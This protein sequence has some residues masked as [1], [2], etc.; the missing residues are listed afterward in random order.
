MQQRKK[1]TSIELQLTISRRSLTKL[2]R[3]QPDLEPPTMNNILKVAQASKHV[4]VPRKVRVD[5]VARQ[6]TSRTYRCL[7]SRSKMVRVVTMAGSHQHTTTRRCSTRSSFLKTCSSTRSTSFKLIGC[8]SKERICFQCCLGCN[9]KKEHSTRWFTRCARHSRLTRA[10]SV[11]NSIAQSKPRLKMLWRV[12]S[13]WSPRWSD[14]WLLAESSISPS[15][16][17]SSIILKPMPSMLSRTNWKWTPKV[18][19][20]CLLRL[21]RRSMTRWKFSSRKIADFASCN[22]L[23]RHQQGLR[24]HPRRRT[25]RTISAK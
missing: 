14:K 3:M 4:Q 21:V 10:T 6:T 24:M 5:R 18:R 19:T 7:V 23:L 9:A 22:F 16:L 25:K 17:R 13:L 11:L 15:Q 2:R 20:T 8:A 12:S 1:T